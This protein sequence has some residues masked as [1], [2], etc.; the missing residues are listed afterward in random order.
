M[1]GKSHYTD[2]QLILK[3]CQLDKRHLGEVYRYMSQHRHYYG[4]VERLATV[5]FPFSQMDAEDIFQ[6]SFWDLVKRVREMG[7]RLTI[8]LSTVLYDIAIKRC[9]NK[10]RNE[11]RRAAHGDKVKKHLKLNIATPVIDSDQEYIRQQLMKIMDSIL[12]ERE[13]SLM[14]SLHYFDW[15]LMDYA[16]VTNINYNTV[17]STS[18]S[19]VRKMAADPNIKTLKNYFDD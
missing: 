14:I 1:F 11:D 9:M 12:T 2:N 13:K 8:K 3:I 7:L 19:A 15:T 16:K 5:S 17:K 6:Q 10:K 18:R 4:Q